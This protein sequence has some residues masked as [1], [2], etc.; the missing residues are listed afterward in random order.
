MA[1]TGIYRSCAGTFRAKACGYRL[2]HGWVGCWLVAV[3]AVLMKHDW[4]DRRRW[5]PSREDL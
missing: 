5:F 2:H 3:G 1:R 4:K